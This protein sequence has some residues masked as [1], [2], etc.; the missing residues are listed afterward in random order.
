MQITKK[1][2]QHLQRLVMCG[3]K[4]KDARAWIEQIKAKHLIRREEFIKKHNRYPSSYGEMYDED[5]LRKFSDALC[6][7]YIAKDNYFLVEELT[8]MTMDEELNNAL[9]NIQVGSEII[10]NVIRK[11]MRQSGQ[12]E[13]AV[14]LN[15]E[16]EQT[17]EDLHIL[18]DLYFKQKDKKK[19]KNLIVNLAK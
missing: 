6:L 15:K 5:D 1:Q 3:R 8:E 4:S 11:S 16:I 7:G 13:E 14:E 10:D 2:L 19:F 18:I 17:R 9:K 12:N